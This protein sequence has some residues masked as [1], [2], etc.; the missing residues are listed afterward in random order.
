MQAASSQAGMMRANSGRRIWWIGKAKSN[1]SWRYSNVVEELSG[2]Q[3]ENELSFGDRLSADAGGY[4]EL[5]EVAS[6]GQL[7]GAQPNL[8]FGPH[9]AEKLHS[10]DSGEQK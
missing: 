8:G 2:A 5:P 7:F 3:A 4:F 1:A 6:L 10:A 9:G